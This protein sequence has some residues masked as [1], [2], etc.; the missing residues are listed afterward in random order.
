M[1]STPI[2]W[3]ALDALIIDFAKSEKLV[4]D[5]SST[6]TTSSS[7]PSSPPSSSSP[8][9]ISSSSYHSRLIIRQIR[10]AL[11]AGHIDAA[12][13]LLRSHAPFILD[14]HRLLF[15]LQKQE[16]YEEFKHV[17]LAF[18]YDKEDQSSPVATE[19]GYYL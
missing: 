1:D 10:R 11:E 15:R 3:E 18:I 8:S 14:D 13:G 7:P 9:S 16:A 4:E 2:N 12:I 17:L 19:V 5:S 6:F